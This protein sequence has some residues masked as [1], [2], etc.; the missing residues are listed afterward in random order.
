MHPLS[1]VHATADT[2][3][4]YNEASLITSSPHSLEVDPCHVETEP[5]VDAC[6][7]GGPAVEADLGADPEEVGGSAT[8]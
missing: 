4:A 7:V 1:I 6:T 8:E 3:Y 2:A 5:D